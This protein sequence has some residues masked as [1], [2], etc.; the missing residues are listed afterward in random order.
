MEFEE[1]D[2]EKYP[3]KIEYYDWYIVQPKYKRKIIINP[4][5]CEIIIKRH[6]TGTDMVNMQ[7]FE[8]FKENMIKLLEILSRDNLQK[9]SEMRDEDK[10]EIGYRDGW[11][12][13]YK[14]IFKDKQTFSGILSDI[15]EE[16]PLEQALTFL[17]TNV[18]EIFLAT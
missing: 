18:L 3:I 11:R 7:Y 17:K 2:F 14:V 15:F 13:H 16:S 12:L 5:D 8:P 1:F 4:L 6:I 10:T 9:Y